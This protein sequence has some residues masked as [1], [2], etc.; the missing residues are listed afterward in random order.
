MHLRAVIRGG[1]LLLFAAGVLLTGCST[2]NDAVPALP[3]LPTT[4]HPPGPTTTTTSPANSI[5][6]TVLPT[7]SSD[8]VR[9]AAS[10]VVLEV[11]QVISARN[12]AALYALLDPQITAGVSESRY[13]AALEVLPVLTNGQPAGEG[14][15]SLQA[16][17]AYWN[18][19]VIFSAKNGT[20]AAQDLVTV[21]LK[22]KQGRWYLESTSGLG[23]VG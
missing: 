1:A 12:W 9:A 14:E 11:A 15:E 3:T 4:T 8:K 7:A 20:R 17:Q 6:G 19:P 18:E 5:R 16:G 2:G 21:V 22:L 10:A 23:T 13:A